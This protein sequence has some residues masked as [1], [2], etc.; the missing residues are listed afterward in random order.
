MGEPTKEERK[1]LKK[2]RKKAARKEKQQQEAEAVAQVEAEAEAP[3]PAAKKSKKKR[4]AEEAAAAAAAA[5]TEGDNHDQSSTSP[6]TKV[7]WALKKG[8]QQKRE[9]YNL[10]IGCVALQL[11][12]EG[13]GLR[14]LLHPIRRGGDRQTCF[15]QKMLLLLGV[16]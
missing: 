16:R 4:K 12:W 1:A 6:P 8:L 3:P 7:R 13:V 15:V 5:A 14:C 9:G 10:V 2:A 11:L